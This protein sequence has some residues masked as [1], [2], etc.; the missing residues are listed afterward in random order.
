MVLKKGERTL[1]ND[2]PAGTCVAPTKPVGEFVLNAPG[3]D[4]NLP[5]ATPETT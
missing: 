3:S 4:N 5:A 1:G 2:L